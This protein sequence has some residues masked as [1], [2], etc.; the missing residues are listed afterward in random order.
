MDR[1]TGHASTPEIYATKM[2]K[3]KHM[4]YSQAMS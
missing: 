2:L 3:K 1:S 4:N